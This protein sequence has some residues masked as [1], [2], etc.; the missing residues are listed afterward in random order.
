[1]SKKINLIVMIVVDGGRGDLIDVFETPNLHELIDRGVRFQNAMACQAF[2]E[3]ASGIATISTGSYIKTHG[4][5]ASHEWYS[6]EENRVVYSVDEYGHAV[7][8]L[9]PTFGDLIKARNPKT[10]IASVSS[11]DRNAILLAGHHA[12]LIIHSYREFPDSFT[13]QG[14]GVLEDHYTF[15]ERKGRSLPSYLRGYQLPRYTN[16]SGNGFSYPHMDTAQTPL[17]DQFIMDAALEILAMERP[18]VLCVGLVSPNIVG[19]YFPIHSN[20]MEDSI[21]MIDRQ[22]GRI[23]DQ[24]DRMGTLDETL[25]VVTSDHGMTPLKGVVDF[26]SLL[27]SELP[28][29]LRKEVA[30]ILL[31]STPGIY[32]RS[33]TPHI[34]NTILEAVRSMDHVAGA[35]RKDDPEAPWFVQR[36]ACDHAPS[37]IAVAEYGYTFLGEYDVRLQGYHGAPYFSD[38]NIMMIFA[39]PDVERMGQIGEPLNLNAPELISESQINR[40]P[41]QVDITPTIE[42]LLGPSSIHRDG[43][44]LISLLNG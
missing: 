8:L 2:I 26:P 11:K 4:V 28:E 40:L 16:W 30:H 18:E 39:G 27:R 34:L 29:K 20:E 1:M 32:L 22:I 33:Q 5:V 41:Q 36:V 44:P 9:A 25:I 24:L 7:N 10:K 12:D 35:W 15:A 19:H 37:I 31:G 23:L 42:H 38:A 14:A 43:N 6:P 3:T 17:M 13:F 21:R